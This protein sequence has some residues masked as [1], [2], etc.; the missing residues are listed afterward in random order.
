MVRGES[1]VNPAGI[2]RWDEG[3]WAPRSSP[4][5]MG[6]IATEAGEG[7]LT[8]SLLVD[9][10]KTCRRLLLPMFER[11]EGVTNPIGIRRRDE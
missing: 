8:T 10:F 5:L 9:T 11:G 3:A 2:R 7:E 1:A 6:N 4:I